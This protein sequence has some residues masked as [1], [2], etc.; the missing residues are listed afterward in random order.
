MA[1]VQVDLPEDWLRAT[2]IHVNTYSTAL[3]SH[4][5]AKLLALELY[6][7]GSVSL[8]RAAELCGAPL[9][10]FAAER[11]VAPHYTIDDLEQDRRFIENL[12]S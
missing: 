10:Q 3:V 5:V 11:E 9:M 2:N 8:G 7:E 6:R 1:T 12:P 4:E